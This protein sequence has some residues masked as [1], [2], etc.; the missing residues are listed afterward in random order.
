[1]ILNNCAP[2]GVSELLPD[3]S[4]LI[5]N[6]CVSHC[7]IDLQQLDLLELAFECV[8]TGKVEMK[9]RRS[10]FNLGIQLH[11]WEPAA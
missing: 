5:Q 3:F 1:M 8:S 9:E 6:Y 11:T 7:I 4:L 10:K 2:L